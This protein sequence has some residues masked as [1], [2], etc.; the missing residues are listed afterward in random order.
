MY[1]VDSAMLVLRRWYV[2]LPVLVLT[3]LAQLLLLVAIPVK[4]QV[5]A[6]IVLVQNGPVNSAANPNAPVN[7]YVASYSLPAL[8]SLLSQKLLAPETAA[9]VQAAGLDGKYEVVPS[10]DQTG[11]I[12]LVAVDTSAVNARR[13]VDLLITTASAQLA[14]WQAGVPEKGQVSA[15][16]LSPPSPALAQN[17]SRIRAMLVVLVLGIGASIYLAFLVESLVDRRRDHS[18]DDPRRRPAKADAPT[19]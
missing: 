14:V 10:I 13:R 2:V 11:S 18:A 4:Y 9:K 6:S 16:L 19:V 15:R 7:P 3:L 1:W 17:G 5:K 12:A 8:G